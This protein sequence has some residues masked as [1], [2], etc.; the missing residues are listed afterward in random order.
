MPQSTAQTTRSTLNLLSLS[1]VTSATCATTVPNDSCTAM[2]RP[3]FSPALPGAAACPSRP[4]RRRARAPRGAADASPAV[5]RRNATGSL[6]AAAA[7]SSMNVSVENAVCVEPTERHHS[8]GTPIV[9]ECSS[10]VEVRNRVR[11]RRRA[12]DAGRVDAVLDHHRLERACRRGSTGRR[13]GAASRRRCRSRRA[14]PSARARTAAGSSRPSC[15]PRASTRA[16]PGCRACRCVTSAFA[17]AT[18]SST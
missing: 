12:L 6:P 10:T 15:R 14:R 18:A 13:S 8:T 17:I 11:Q 16:S 9:G 7:S 4:S 2:P 3:R 5:A 1:T